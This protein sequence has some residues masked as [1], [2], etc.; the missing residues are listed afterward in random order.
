MRKL[1]GKTSLPVIIVGSGL[2]AGTEAESYHTCWGPQLEGIAQPK[3]PWL[4][5]QFLGS[6]TSL[7]WKPCLV[8]PGFFKVWVADFGFLNVF[9]PLER[10]RVLVAMGPGFQCHLC[11]CS[12]ASVTSFRPVLHIWSF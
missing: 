11:H 5:R 3:L 10:Q 12:G 6:G 8:E 1:R 4:Q 7:L 9:S 2:V